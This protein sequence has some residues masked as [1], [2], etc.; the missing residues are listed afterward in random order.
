MILLAPLIKLMSIQVSLVAALSLLFISSCSNKKINKDPYGGSVNTSNYDVDSLPAPFATKS[1]QNFSMVVGWKD[2]KTPVA[3]KGFTVTKFADGFDHPRWIYVADNGDIFVAESNTILKGIKKVG[4][5]IS[6]KIKTHHFGESANRITMFRDANKDGVPESRH[7]FMENLNQPFGMLILNNKFYVANTDEL[8]RYDYK[9][10]D[11][12]I[13][14]SGDTILRFTKSKENRHWTRNIIADEAGK[15]IYVAIGSSSNVA[16]NGLEDEIRRACIL[17]I[18]ADGTGEKMYAEGLRNPVGIAWAPGTQTLWAA[19]NERDEL[20]DELVP[21][22]FTSVTPGKFYGW[23][24]AYFGQNADPRLKDKQRP[25]LVQKTLVPDIPLGSHTASLGLVFYEKKSFPSKYQ[26]GAFIT[27]HGSWNR[28][29]IS[30]Y[31]VVFI[32]FKNG[33]PSGP[34]ED[35]LTGF[36]DDLTKSKVHGRPVGIAVLPDG[37]MLVSD[38]VNNII[39][40]IKSQN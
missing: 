39:W 10:G 31:K 15:K 9:K 38:D 19:V 12:S 40:R 24:F 30:G 13:R 1:I 33:K 28:S 35:F 26:N 18:N 36:I 32:P 20:G 5:K 14:S 3:P 22:Y 16:E 34:P 8:V 29:V 27:Q 37:S 7:V 2:G 11:T 21:D 4:S 6:R 25:D 23:P 17:E